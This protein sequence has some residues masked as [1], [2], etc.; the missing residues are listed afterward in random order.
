M[1]LEGLSPNAITFICMWKAFC[2][3][4]YMERGQEVHIGIVKQGFEKDHHAGSILVEMYAKHRWLQE[5]QK[6]FDNIPLKDAALW[7]ALI[8][9][10]ADENLLIELFESMN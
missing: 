3:L 5:A 8:F 4:E 7:N 10:Y 6:V 9:A 2:S 1:Q